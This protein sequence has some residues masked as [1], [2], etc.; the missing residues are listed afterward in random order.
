MYVLWSG[1]MQG[2]FTTSGNYSNDLDQA[3]R[4]ERTAALVFARK[5]KTQ[6]A[7]GMLPVALADLEAI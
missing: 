4:F 5:H 2:W 6:G 7:H 3:Q 1:K